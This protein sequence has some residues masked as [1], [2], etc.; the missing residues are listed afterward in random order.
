MAENADQCIRIKALEDA[1]KMFRQLCHEKN[2]WADVADAFMEW[3][4]DQCDA[5][6][7]GA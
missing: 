5:E 2:H 7:D 3:I 4:D 6:K 1:R